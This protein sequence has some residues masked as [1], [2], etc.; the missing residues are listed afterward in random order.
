[1]RLELGRPIRCS[2]GEFGELADVVVDPTTKRVTHVV[3]RPH[4]LGRCFPS[5]SDRA[6]QRQGR[7]DARLLDR[8]G[9]KAPR[10]P[11]DGVPPSR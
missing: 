8:R 1:M 4:K 3:A 2:D 11:G 7:A 9:H 5:R 10:A 6:C